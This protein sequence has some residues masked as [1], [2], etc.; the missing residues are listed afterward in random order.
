MFSG[1]MNLRKR[2]TTDL[3]LLPGFR[4]RSFPGAE[5]RLRLPLVVDSDRAVYESAAGDRRLDWAVRWSHYL[6]SFDVGL[7]HF[8]GTN[9]EPRLVPEELDGRPVLVPHYDVID[10]TGMDVQYTTGPWLW[11]AEG[12]TRTGGPEGRMW[13]A[14]VGFERTSYQV[15]GTDADVGLIVEYLWDDRAGAASTPFEDDIF[16]G[17]RLALNDVQSSAL[18]V[19]SVIDR[20]TGAAFYRVEGERRVGDSFTVTL[21]TRGVWGAEPTEPLGAFRDDDFV[22]LTVSWWW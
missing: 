18:L 10:Q 17:A 1:G 5:G 7:S 4:E 13:A 20:D 14:T 22:G 15:L 8:Q 3:F 9:R 11:K 16:L 21:E 19:G 12:I 2:R 6:G